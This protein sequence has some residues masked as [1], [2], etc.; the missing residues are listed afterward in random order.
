ML[1]PIAEVVRCYI[2]KSQI[3]A[4]LIV[5]HKHKDVSVGLDKVRPRLQLARLHLFCDLHHTIKKYMPSRTL[6]RKEVTHADPSRKKVELV[7]E[8]PGSSQNH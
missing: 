4:L 5:S 8:V 1:T 2:S 3:P 7:V 6:S